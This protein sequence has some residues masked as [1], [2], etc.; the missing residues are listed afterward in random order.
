MLDKEGA[1][2]A[3]D[4]AFIGDEEAWWRPSAS[5]PAAGATDFVAGIVG[6]AG[7]AG[8]GL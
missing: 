2:A 4:I 5:W 8:P 6:D 3:A 7:R 1:D